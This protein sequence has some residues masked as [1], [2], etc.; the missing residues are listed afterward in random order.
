MSHTI[1]DGL[2]AHLR[3]LPIA[4]W[5]SDYEPANTSERP[6]P[7]QPL[8]VSFLPVGG[9]FV[10]CVR[11]GDGEVKLPLADWSLRCGRTNDFGWVL[12]KERAALGAEDEQPRSGWTKKPLAAPAGVRSAHARDAGVDDPGD[13]PGDAEDAGVFRPRLLEMFGSNDAV[14]LELDAQDANAEALYVLPNETHRIFWSYDKTLFERFLQEFDSEPSAALERFE[15]PQ[16]IVEPFRTGSAVALLR[17]LSEVD[18][19]FVARQLSSGIEG[20]HAGWPSMDGMSAAIFDGTPAVLRTLYLCEWLHD[21][22]L[23]MVRADPH[24]PYLHALRSVIQAA[25]DGA[26]IPDLAARMPTGEKGKRARQMRGYL[27]MLAEAGMDDRRVAADLIDVGGDSPLHGHWVV[28]AKALAERYGIQHPAMLGR[29][30]SEIAQPAGSASSSQGSVTAAERL[31]VREFHFSPDERAALVAYFDMYVLGFR[32][33]SDAEA[34]DAHWAYVERA[35]GWLEEQK[36]ALLDA[37]GPTTLKRS[38]ALHVPR[39]S[40]EYRAELADRFHFLCATAGVRFWERA[41]A[42]LATQSA[43]DELKPFVVWMSEG[44]GLL[45]KV[46]DGFLQR[47]LPAYRGLLTESAEQ[48]VQYLY[49]Y[50]LTLSGKGIQQA[51]PACD[52]IV[53]IEPQ[54]QSGRA[55]VKVLRRG[56]A[57]ELMEMEVLTSVFAAPADEPH[58]PLGSTDTRTRFKRFQRAMQSGQVRSFTAVQQTVRVADADSETLARFPK[59]L[60]AVAALL[61]TGMAVHALIGELAKKKPENVDTKFYLDVAQES[62]AAVEPG[63]AL[64]APLFERAGPRASSVGRALTV[65]AGYLNRASVALESVRHVLTGGA[66][67]LTF[68]APKSSDTDLARYLA[69]RRGLPAVLETTKGMLQVAVGAAG[70]T[71]LVIGTATTVATLPISTW[72]VVGLVAVATLDVL[73]YVDTGGSSPVQAFLNKVREAREA[74]FQLEKRRILLPDETPPGQ[75]GEKTSRSRSPSLLAK[76]LATVHHVVSTRA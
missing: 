27:H 71:G 50:H 55:V 72:F 60:A 52:V 35:I 11:V 64:L 4:L 1:P 13:E 12:L 75:F 67:L 66:T 42:E 6:E 18:Q 10:A 49:R 15:V 9:A 32:Q 76:R 5:R 43:W 63:V 74:Q 73:I 22:C 56:R 7:R 58:A 3:A 48:A 20:F 33:R 39:S 14:M 28:L 37:V 30:P 38:L 70:G 34:L 51:L 24:W 68:F 36:F 59:R 17:E 21:S 8:K 53:R 26:A 57:T 16:Y 25:N 45:E 31:N 29:P 40:L 69:E 41:A 2:R 19:G 44:A 65:G 54:A 46:F 62:F 23:K 47:Y 61:D